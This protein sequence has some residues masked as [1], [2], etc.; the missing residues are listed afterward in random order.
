LDNDVLALNVAEFP[1]AF[2]QRVVHSLV[3]ECDKPNQPLLPDS[4]RLPCERPRGRRAAEQRDEIASFHSITSSARA[5]SVGGISRPSNLAVCRLI[6]NSNLVAC[7][8]G[9]SAGLAPLSMRPT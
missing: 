4:W 2:E 3:S 7:T 8:T 5:M 6:T 1:Q 9:R